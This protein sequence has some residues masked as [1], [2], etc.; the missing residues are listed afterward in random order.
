MKNLCIVLTVLCLISSSIAQQCSPPPN[1][2]NPKEC[3]AVPNIMPSKEQFST[4]IQ[5]FPPPSGPPPTPGS[6]PPNANCIAECILTQQ[7]AIS[8]GAISKDAAISQIVAVVGSSSD[9]QAL[10]KSAVEKCYSQVS[11]LGTQKD[12]NGCS[13][14]AGPFVECL[15]TEMFKNC[16]AASWTA[17][18][19][20]D[21]LKA[22]LA[23]GCSIMS[24]MP[25]PHPH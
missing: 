1:T 3:C 23:K 2:K 22:H 12:S 6:L 11:S 8:N 24:L 13:S 20:C 17:G 18:A 16:P 25:P 21:Q 5:K 7:G 9:W 19:E 15:P 14:A 10:A 4:C